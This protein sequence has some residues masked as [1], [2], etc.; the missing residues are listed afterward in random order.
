MLQLE[1]L[2]VEF[3]VR[4]RQGPAILTALRAV[5]LSV[6]RGEAVALVGESGS[7]KSTLGRAALRLLEPAGGRIFFEGTDVTQLSQ[8]QLR[9]L[10][11]RAQLI[12]QDPYASLD[13]RMTVGQQIAEA[14]W[15]HRLARR[16]DL[17]R[18]V[19]ELLDQ[20][21]LGGEVRDRFPNALSGGQ[22]QRVGIARAL[23]VDPALLIL[24][25][26]L[27]ALD[28][29]IQ[30]QIVNLLED[31]QQEFNLT[32]VFIAHDLSVVRHVSDRVAVMYLGRIAEIGPVEEI[33]GRA[34]HPYTASL[35]SAVPLP[36]AG[37]VGKQR[38]RVILSGGVPSP[39][40]PPSGCRFHPRCPKAQEICSEKEPDLRHIEGDPESRL[41]ACHFPVEP[42]DALAAAAWEDWSGVESPADATLGAEP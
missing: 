42:G 33:Y 38:E 7:G 28:V 14:L 34:R 16:R 39:I 4:G 25:E 3:H 36:E 22:R 24:D 27:S 35:L 19:A 40:N 18:R 1:A 31:L 29:S 9:P 11:R 21:G 30:A 15:I 32:L 12:F 37:L 17:P 23:A 26:P 20:V 13:P 8:A 5:D 10:R 2:R 41:V 6:G